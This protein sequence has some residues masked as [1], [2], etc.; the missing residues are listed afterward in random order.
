MKVSILTL[1]F[2]VLIRKKAANHRQVESN[3]TAG[4]ALSSRLTMN[5]DPAVLPSVSLG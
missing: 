2:Q 1:F 5:V 3:S 4:M